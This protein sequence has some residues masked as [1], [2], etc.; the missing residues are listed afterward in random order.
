MQF[1]RLGQ[2]RQLAAIIKSGE[3]ARSGRHST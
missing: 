3:A 2:S 1:A